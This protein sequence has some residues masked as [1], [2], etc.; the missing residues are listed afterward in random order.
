LTQF[1]GGRLK[2]LTDA[3]F[4]TGCGGVSLKVCHT[5]S[6]DATAGRLDVKADELR[7]SV[8]QSA[9]DE[10]GQRA[11]RRATPSTPTPHSTEGV[12]SVIDGLNQPEKTR[13]EFFRGPK[14]PLNIRRA[15]RQQ[16]FVSVCE[17]F[18]VG[19]LTEGFQASI[20][21]DRR[22]NFARDE[23]TSVHEAGSLRPSSAASS[24]PARLGIAAPSHRIGQE[25]L[26]W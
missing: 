23:R 9:V 11:A 4:R 17:Q 26:C 6:A 20:L 16:P 24:I 1:S 13:N 22:Q 25:F 8:S 10:R 5:G 7:Q 14:P 18:F 15:L 21:T 19:E 2:N 12:I 3:A